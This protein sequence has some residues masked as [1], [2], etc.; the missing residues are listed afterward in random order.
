[1]I[2]SSQMSALTG[3]AAAVCTGVLLHLALP[4]RSISILIWIALLPLLWAAQRAG[5][6][7]TAFYLGLTAGLVLCVLSL[8]WLTRL[9]GPAAVSL[10]VLLALWP[11][12]FALWYFSTASWPRLPRAVAAAAVWVGLEFFRSELWWFEFTWLTPGSAFHSTPAVLQWA[13]IIGVYGLS[14]IVVLVNGLLAAALGGSWAAGL[15]ALIMAIALY[16]GG[17]TLTPE[18]APGDIRVAAVQHEDY[19]SGRL[20]QLSEQAAAERRDFLIWP[21]G[22]M[23]IPALDTAA[24]DP[25]AGLARR[26]NTHLIAGAIVGS[27]PMARQNPEDCALVFDPEG[28]YLG[29]HTKVH[30]VPLM[31]KTFFGGGFAR[32]P[33]REVFP[34]THGVAGVQICFDENFTDLSRRLT[35]LGAE[36]FLVPSYDPAEWGNVE[37]L[38]HAALLSF[39][40]VESRRWI[41]R[42][43][44]SG[45]SE[46]IDPAGRR[47]ASLALNKEG[48]LTATIAARKARTI[49]PRFGWVLPYL[50][51]AVT[52]ALFGAVFYLG[53]AKG[54]LA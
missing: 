8:F 3:F 11:A 47:V 4:P 48:V 25:L 23:S 18:V 35:G 27:S 21:E 1:M 34:T 28:K 9:F 5:S 19:A 49:Y 33:A 12:L 38:Q 26:W 22:A 36:F 10:W 50:C 51:V 7:R 52:V 31:E 20:Y 53:E 45:P 6:A 2:R 44:S 43:S 14:F 24:L 17:R 13:S 15:A 39:R 29:R 40:A 54:Y 42:A 30:L 41:V 16:A 37:R 32:R 46:A